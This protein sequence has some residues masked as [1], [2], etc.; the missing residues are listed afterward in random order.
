[1]SRMKGN[2][3][4]MSI[5]ID[6]EN[7]YDRLNW[8]FVEKCLKECNFPH[9]IIQLIHHLISSPSY[10]ILWNREKTD[11]IIP[12]RGI[13]LC[14]SVLSSI[15]YYHMQY[16]KH[17]R[18]LCV[19]MEKIQRGFIWGDTE[20]GRKPHLVGWDVICLSKMNG[21]LGLKRPH[22]M[23]E[24]FLM[25]MLWNL[26]T[27]PDDLW[28]KVLLSKYGTNND[29]SSSIKSQ[30]YDSPLWK[31]LAG[32]WGEFQRNIVWKIG[33]GLHTNFWLDKWGSNNISLITVPTQS[34]IDTIL[35]VKDV[36]NESGNWDD[37]F[38]FQ[39]LPE[40]HCD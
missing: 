14:N 39:N 8:N 12:T 26:N 5:K 35:N 13:A 37:E 9:K 17:P 40:K 21:G 33:D 27:K 38:F 22:L 32:T 2:K 30:P 24:A 7:A 11:T 28:C 29:L 31:A 25:K 19:E 1:M 15:P 18:T 10:K 3:M 4:F 23:N 16:A 34:C 20:Q 6:L 36:T